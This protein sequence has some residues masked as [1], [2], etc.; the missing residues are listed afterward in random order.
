[1][2]SWL[3]FAVVAGAATPMSQQQQAPPYGEEIVVTASLESEAADEL[4]VSVDVV[5]A[6]EIRARQA[7]EV[8]ELLR[9]LPGLHVTQSG[10]PG[11]V[12]SLFTR[13]AESNQTLVLWNGLPL[14][15]PYFGGFDFAFLPTD[16]VRRIEVARGPFSALYGSQAMGGVVQVLTGGRRGGAVRLEGGS[17]D[18]GRAGVSWGEDLGAV[19][20]D[21]AGHLRRGDGAADNE[22]YDGEDLMASLAWHA[23]DSVSASLVARAAHAEIGIP[24]AAGVSTP[25]RRQESDSA[26]LAVPVVAELGDWRLETSLSYSQ[27]DLLF[28]DVDAVFSRSDTDAERWRGRSVATYRGGDDF[29][30]AVGGE[31]QRDE[32]T[33]RTNF[34]IDLDAESRR[35][36]GVFGELY[37]VLGPVRLDLGVRRDEDEFFGSAVSPRAGLVVDLGH[38]VE[39]FASYGK[40]FRAPSL[41]ELFF[42]FYGNP[43]LEAEKSESLE[44]GLRRFGKRWS[45]GVTY[46][47][48]DFVNLIDADPVSFTA[49]NIGRAK[50][51][52]VEIRAGYRRGIAQLEIDA[53]GLSTED[54]ATG[55]AL[56]RRPERRADVVLTLAP[57]DCLVELVGRY[58][59]ERV[60][61]D[62]VTFARASN[63]A[64]LVG[65]VAVT[66]QAMP[67]LAPYGRLENVTD[68]QYE[69]V[70]GFPAPGLRWVVGLEVE[71][72]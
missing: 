8:F 37:Q 69:E 28:S 57:G 53:T 17:Y 61:L 38:D 27:S 55:E 14:N 22:Y 19:E 2:W 43:D 31:W 24:T 18:Y 13:G 9:T 47:A 67:R 40:G 11:T 16:G 48:T 71:L 12:V 5:D 60:D 35:G 65:D 34:G 52:G 21:V 58:V 41:G 7:T 25:R 49:V 30:V 72:P 36:Y 15:D 6:E 26:Q 51:R 59:G 4:P 23:S 39:L 56:L 20:L 10:A 45:V 63:D 62:P 68:E 54:L 64:Y 46:F 29:W 66:W 33:S 32:V 44:A 70:L 50:S 1:M 3:F 42:P